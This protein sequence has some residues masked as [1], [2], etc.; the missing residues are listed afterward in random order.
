MFAAGA[1][2][3]GDPQQI[4]TIATQDWYKIVAL[5]LGIVGA[6]LATANVTVIGDLLKL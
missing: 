2:V 4:G 6:L 5:I 1:Y 3:S